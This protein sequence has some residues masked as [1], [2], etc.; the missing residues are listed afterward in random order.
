MPRPKPVAGVLLQKTATRLGWSGRGYHRVLRVA[1]AIAEAVQLR[2][3]L[4]TK[5]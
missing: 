5:G 1:R 2:R 4:Q 3:G